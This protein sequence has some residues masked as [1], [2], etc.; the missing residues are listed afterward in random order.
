MPSKSKKQRRFFGLVHQA[1]QHMKNKDSKESQK[2]SPEVRKVAK[3]M[4]HKSVQDFVKTPEKDLPL[5]LKMEMLSILKELHE[6]AML[7]ESQTNPIAKEFTIK[8]DYDAVVGN[9]PG[10]SSQRGYDGNPFSQKELESISSFTQVKPAPLKTDAKGNTT[11]IKYE[12]SDQFNNNTTTTIMKLN[13]GSQKAYSAFT[14]YS[15]TTPEEPAQDQAPEMGAPEPG[16]PE[17]GQPPAPPVQEAQSAQPTGQPGATQAE[18]QED[19]IVANSVPFTDDE[20]GAKILSNFLRKL[21][22]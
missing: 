18:E 15:R 14:K 9:K 1:Q 20:E 17:P 22:L 2:F 10:S 19:I 16:A 13:A 7:T 8:G 4:S 11:Q 5:K 6:P 3:T 21:D 12:T